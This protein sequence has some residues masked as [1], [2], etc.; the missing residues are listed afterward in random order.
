MEI[1][2]VRKYSICKI[3]I[4]FGEEIDLVFMRWYIVEI[5]FVVVLM[6]R[7]VRVRFNMK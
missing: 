1:V 4:K 7:F 3:V 2:Y 5:G 6:R